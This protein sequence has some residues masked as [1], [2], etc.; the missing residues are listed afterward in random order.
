VECHYFLANNY[1][2][3]GYFKDAYTHLTVYLEK[4]PDGDF[5]E[6]AEDLLEVL[7]LE[8]DVLDNDSYAHDDLITKQEQA[9]QLLESGHI[10][11]AIKLLKS[12]IKDFPEYWSA[13]NNLALAYFYLGEEEKATNILDLV[14]EKNPGNFHAFCNKLVFAFFQKNAKEIEA[15]TAV[16]KKV[17]PLIL[18]HQYKLGATFALIGE[19]ETA[20]SWFYRLYKHG[21]EGDGSFYYWFSYVFLLSKSHHKESILTKNEVQNNN[22]FSKLENQYVT[23]VKAGNQIDDSQM[24]VAHETAQ[25]L[26][27]HHHPI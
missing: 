21:Y 25:L 11:K 13:Y 16:L 12:V 27:Q 20:Y 14:M 7:T 17:N 18:E 23:M 1:A 9:K 22:K 26:Y 19:Y 2:H 5:T 15:F 10:P 6:E 8:E 24:A 4:D 3:L